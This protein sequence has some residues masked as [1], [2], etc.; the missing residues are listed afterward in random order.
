[1]AGEVISLFLAM[2]VTMKIESIV[3][4]VVGCFEEAKKDKSFQIRQLTEKLV[5]VLIEKHVFSEALKICVTAENSLKRLELVE[6]LS[7]AAI[8]RKEAFI[9]LKD[10]QV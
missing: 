3:D 2:N 5:D 8:R 10:P 4:F 9:H 1:M 7:L 6:S